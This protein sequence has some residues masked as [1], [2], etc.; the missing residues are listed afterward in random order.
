MIPCICLPSVRL[1]SLIT[2]IFRSIHVATNGI[3]SFFYACVIF[4]CVCVCVCICCCSL[5]CVQQGASQALLSSTISWSLLKV[6]SVE[7]VMLSN[8]LILCCPP[9]LLPSIFPSIRVFSKELP[10]RIK[11]PKYWSFSN[12]HFL[13][14]LT[15]LISY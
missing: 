2:V 12:S 10:L 5:S 4:V 13:L 15:D 9:F 11:W 3:I 1:T 14:E 7:S 8:H 6:M